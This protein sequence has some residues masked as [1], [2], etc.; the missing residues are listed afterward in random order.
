MGSGASAIASIEE[1]VLNARDEIVREHSS[2]NNDQACF[3]A[4]VAC[5]QAA[6]VEE[7]LHLLALT[8]QSHAAAEKVASALVEIAAVLGTSKPEY[9]HASNTLITLLL[10]ERD[11]VGLRPK[12][13]SLRKVG[14]NLCECM[15]ARKL[16]W[17][18]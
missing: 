14:N 9:V 6:S 2:N 13:E 5:E 4:S 1:T 12:I 7:T 8:K 15:H 3:L 11:L 18:C 17:L 16:A 10:V